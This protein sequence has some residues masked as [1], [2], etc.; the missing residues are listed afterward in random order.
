MLNEL[1][2]I[3]NAHDLK[4]E[5]SQSISNKLTGAY[6]KRWDKKVPGVASWGRG[7]PGKDTLINK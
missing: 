4:G 5:T 3:E 2:L 7:G 1:L 6:Y